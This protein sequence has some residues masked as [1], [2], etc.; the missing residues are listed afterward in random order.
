MSLSPP[1]APVAGGGGV[2]GGQLRGGRARPTPRWKTARSGRRTPCGFGRQEDGAQNTRVQSG[3][4]V[5]F[6]L[7]PVVVAFWSFFLFF[8]EKANCTEELIAGKSGDSSGVC[9]SHRRHWTRMR[10]PL[11]SPI[12][13]VSVLSDGLSGSENGTCVSCLITGC[14]FRDTHHKSNR[15]FSGNWCWTAGG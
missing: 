4:F 15:S 7:P 9:I 8:F 1:R 3:A 11:P 10:F 13:L 6:S 12:Y 5:Q 14:L 2:W